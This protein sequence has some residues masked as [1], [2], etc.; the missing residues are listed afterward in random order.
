MPGSRFAQLLALFWVVFATFMFATFWT[1]ANSQALLCGPKAVVDQTLTGFEA[2]VIGLATS[3]TFM[4]IRVNEDG[5]WVTLFTNPEGNT[6][7]GSFGTD[8]EEL[9]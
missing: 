6:C 2:E 7:I 4:E 8:Y 3:G 5:R 1:S 9:D